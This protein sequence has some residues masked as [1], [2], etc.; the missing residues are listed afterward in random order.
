MLF[1]S[2]AVCGQI[3]RSRCFLNFNR[4]LITDGIVVSLFPLSTEDAAGSAELFE[5]LFMAIEKGTT[6]ACAPEYFYAIVNS[7]P[8][9]FK[10]HSLNRSISFAAKLCPFGVLGRSGASQISRGS[11]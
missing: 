9:S 11:N 8:F 7:G 3:T 2:D 10:S 1:K 5:Y 4:F 6:V